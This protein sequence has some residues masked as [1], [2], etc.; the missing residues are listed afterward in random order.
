[1]FLENKKWGKKP[2]SWNQASVVPTLSPKGQNF[3]PEV[4]DRK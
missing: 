1:M 3:E 2:G 4:E